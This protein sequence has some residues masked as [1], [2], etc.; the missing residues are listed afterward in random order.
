MTDVKQRKRDL[1]AVRRAIAALDADLAAGRLTAEEHARQRA[2]REREVGRLFLSLRDAQQRAAGD[3]R[4]PPP[5]APASRAPSWLRSPWA[6]GATA[7]LLLAASV[8][9]GVV[10][11]SRWSGP[12]QSAPTAAGPPAASAPDPTAPMGDIALRALERVVSGNDA[13]VESLLQYG[14]VM[15]DQGKVDE[16]QKVYDRVV[17]REPRNVEAITHLGA[18]LHQRGRVDEALAKVDEALRIDPKY[19]H[20]LWDRTQYLFHTKQDYPAAVRAAQAF[21]DVV[22]DGQDADHVKKLLDDARKRAAARAR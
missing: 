17:A 12:R 22:P 16:A 9:A 10:L 19:V 13:S 8:G 11:A 18:V 3:R 2:E 6:L 21:L 1:E 15:L 5:P 14:H 7:L 20:A 4:P